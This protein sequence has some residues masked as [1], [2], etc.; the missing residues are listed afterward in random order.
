[1][2]RHNI[3]REIKNVNQ[4]SFVPTDVLRAHKGIA[5][6][7]KYK[8]R[9]QNAT[10]TDTA[11]NSTHDTLYN[12]ICNNRNNTT[13][14]ISIAITEHFSKPKEILN[15]RDLVDLLTG[16]IHKKVAISIPTNERIYYDKYHHSNVFTLYPRS[17][18]RKLWDD[19]T[20]SLI[21]NREDNMARLEGASNHRLEFI[22]NIYAKFHK[23]SPPSA[24]SY[25]PTP[26]KLVNQKA[27]INPKNNNNKRF[28]Y[29]TGISVFYDEIDMKNPS[30]VSKKSLTC[31]D[32]L[33]ID[34]I[35]FPPTIK[36]IEQFEKDNLD[37]PI[38]IFE[39]GGFH[40]IKE[41]DNNDD[42]L[43]KV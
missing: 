39:Y 2:Q 6:Q 11:R 28:L 4:P 36:N 23:I 13:H 14:K 19:L 9:N 21:Q 32:R 38:T 7:F 30:R 20:T 34:N 17:S 43:K 40:K 27:I 10:D 24:R 25:I 41:D 12:L 3:L 31:C 29:S 1:M 35:N 37:I 33:N 18:I 42:I 26:K 22:N 5:Q 16:V 8:A 15:D